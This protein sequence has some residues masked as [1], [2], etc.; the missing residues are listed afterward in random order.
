MCAVSR[1]PPRLASL[2]DPPHK[3]EGKEEEIAR[4]GFGVLGKL[5]A[6]CLPL[7]L[8]LSTGW[9]GRPSY[10]STP[11]RSRTHSTRVRFSPCSTSIARLSSV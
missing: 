9:I 5:R 2:A 1:P 8:P 6:R 10:S 4:I 11:P 7:T 3:G